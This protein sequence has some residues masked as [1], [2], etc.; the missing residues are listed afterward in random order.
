MRAIFA[1][2]MKCCRLL[3]WFVVLKLCMLG[4]GGCL[5]SD[6]DLPCELEVEKSVF[7]QN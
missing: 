1:N 3:C 2:V 5:L 6:K 4:V 7:L